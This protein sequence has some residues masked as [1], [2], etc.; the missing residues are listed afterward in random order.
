M[1]T[2]P[3]PRSTPRVLVV[4]GGVGG[5]V[6]A[7]RLAHAG[8][9]VQVLEAAPQLGGKAAPQV[10]DGQRLDAGPTVL[11][12]RWVFDELWEQLGAPEPLPLRRCELLARHWWAGGSQLDLCADF[13]ASCDAVG[14]FAGA[15]A[16]LQLRAFAA[17]AEGIYRTLERPFIRAAR[18]SMLG[19]SAAV[20]RERGPRALFGITPFRSLWQSLEQ[21]FR[22]P[23]LRQLFGRYATYCGSSPWAAPAT[24]MLIAHVEREAVWQLDGGVAALAEALAALAR[25]QGAQ[26]RVNAPVAELLLQGRRVRGV[27]LASGERLEAE[28]VV[29]NGDADALAQGLLGTAV[30]QALGTTPLRAPQRSLSALVWLAR[31]PLR[32][33]PLS[34]HNVF[35]GPAYAEE[36]RAVS[37][38]RLPPWPSAYLCAQDR[39]ALASAPAPTGPERLQL[40]VNAPARPDLSPEEIAECQQQTEAQLKACGLSLSLD[41]SP[42]CSLRGPAQFAQ[43]Y[44]GTQGALY[45]RAAQGWRASFQRPVQRTAVAGLYLAGGSTH[46]GPGLPMAALSARQAALQLLADLASIRKFH[47]VAMPGGTSMR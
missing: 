37:D 42:Q 45:G 26:L 5:L 12:M 25:R 10:V 40:L 9:D 31:A 47:P 6:A 17:R 46:P 34:H 24:L 33:L 35:F 11:T 27:R 15:E 3:L 41:P 38:G 16:A 20:L 4:G 13:E 21:Q 39:P 36:F 44:P 29:F 22:D 32:G 30:A 1:Q 19:L 2:T 23:R 14:R 43:A 7:A 8:L 18:P 28:A